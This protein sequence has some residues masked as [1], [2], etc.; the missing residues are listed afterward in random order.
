MD[1]L[2]FRRSAFAEPQSQDPEFLAAAQSSPERTALLLQLQALDARVSAAAQSVPVPSGLADRL[3]ALEEPAANDAVV[4]NKSKARRYIAVAA[5]L[6]V[7]IGLILSPGLIT[8]RPSASDLKFHDEVIGHVYRE[9]ARYDTKRED[10]SIVQIN[11]VLEEA[12]GHLRNEE[13]IKQMHIKFANGCNIASNGKGAHIVLDGEKGSV[14]VMVVHNSPVTTTFDVND[15]RF[16]GKIIP[17][18]EG[19]LIIVGEKDEPLD[20]YQAMIS[21]AFEWSI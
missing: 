3:K 17:F 6:V 5:S 7:A 4:E 1:D 18:G 19:N 12:G 21:E 9:V 15:S 13:R 14:S 10:A 20:K 16:A 2:E 11:S 8:A